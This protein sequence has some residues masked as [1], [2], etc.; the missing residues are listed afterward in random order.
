VKTWAALLMVMPAMVLLLL[1][2]VVPMIMVGRLSLFDTD[3]LLE[4]FVG[5]GNFI[6]L[7]KDARFLRT[8]INVFIYLIPLI[9][10]TVVVT[11]G[12]ASM[13]SRFGPKTQSVGRFVSYLP[14]LTAGLIVALLWKWLLA[15][16]GLFNQYLV[17]WGMQSI[18]WLTQPWTARLSM[19][20]VSM[21]GGPG[22][23]LIL[24]SAAIASIPKELH[25]AAVIDGA[26]ESQYR[27]YIVRPMMM[28]MIALIMLLCIVGTMQVWE[29]VYVLTGEGGPK[30][31]T[32]TPVYD[33]FQTA[34]VFNRP[35]YAA[36]KGI[37]LLVVIG[38]LVY[39]KQ[40]VEKWSAVEA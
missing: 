33:L 25:D 37:V 27:R 26:S 10:F 23:L 7:V 24:S 21:T 19:V 15:R 38:M 2:F 6:E 4:K 30:G 11:Y 13:L 28:P 3:Y 22:A 5:L 40:R 9:P 1:T 35:G 17:S 8:F 39:I 36:A 14:S 34:F 12:M 29:T 18:P 16:E 31:S 20:L 32:S